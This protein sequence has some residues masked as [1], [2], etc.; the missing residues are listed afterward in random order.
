MEKLCRLRLFVY[1]N[2]EFLYILALFY[3]LLLLGNV[4]NFDLFPLS[5]CYV[6]ISQI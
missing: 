6:N 3:K 5:S 4:F 2:S 1:F